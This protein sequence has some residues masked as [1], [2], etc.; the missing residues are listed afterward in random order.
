MRNLAE[1]QEKRLSRPGREAIAAPSKRELQRR[2]LFEGEIVKR[3]IKDSLS[4]LS[5]RHQIKKTLL[6][7][8]WAA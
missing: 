6:N 5:P 8:K 7:I 4:K 3:A 1:T 2:S